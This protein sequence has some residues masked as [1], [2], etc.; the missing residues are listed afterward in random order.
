MSP[1]ETLDLSVFRAKPAN[2]AALLFLADRLLCHGKLDPD[3]AAH[4]LALVD[5]AI[6]T[7]EFAHYRTMRL[8]V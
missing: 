1:S 7:T 4:V 3:Y 8:A 2:G 5:G 6:T